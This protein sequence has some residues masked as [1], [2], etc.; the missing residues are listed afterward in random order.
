[1][2]FVIGWIEVALFL[3]GGRRYNPSDT[4]FTAPKMKMN[5]DK[6][7]PE[8]SSFLVPPHPPSNIPFLAL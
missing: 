6:L 7:C 5:V 4:D 2:A 3:N 1:M 8:R